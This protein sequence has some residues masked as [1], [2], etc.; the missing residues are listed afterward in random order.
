MDC[1]GWLGPVDCPPFILEHAGVGCL[2]FVLRFAGVAAG[3]PFESSLEKRG[4]LRPHFGE[5]GFE[6]VLVGDRQAALG[7]DWAGV[8][9]WCHP[10]D[11]ETDLGVAA[12]EGPLDG[13]GTAV[14]GQERRM[15]VDGAESR[16]C[17]QIRGE[18][19]GHAAADDEVGAER[20]EHRR[21]AVRVVGDDDVDAGRNGGDHVEIGGA[22]ATLRSRRGDHADD[23]VTE[24]AQ[25][26]GH[27]VIDL[28]A[29]DVGD[30]DDVPRVRRGSLWFR[31]QRGSPHEAK[32]SREEFSR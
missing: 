29:G 5:E 32:R 20:G 23:A 8:E 21:P 7:Q 14:A 3:D 11:G 27:N 12:A 1:A 24:W 9:T 18:V 6:I 30:D 2:G 4:N 31:S 22:A 10:V 13:G 26:A 28:T 16:Q 25:N 19:P 17:Q 15:D